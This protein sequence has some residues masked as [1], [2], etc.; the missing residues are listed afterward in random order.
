MDGGDSAD[1]DRQI[2]SSAYYE[3]GSNLNLIANSG[4]SCEY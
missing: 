4:G 2:A 1:L 3:T